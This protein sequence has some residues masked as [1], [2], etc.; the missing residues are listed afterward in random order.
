MGMATLKLYYAHCRPE[1]ISECAHVVRARVD[2]NT[3]Q[4]KARKRPGV[5]LKPEASVLSHD[6]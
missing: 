5:R 1:Q 6:F 2:T 3:E 4:V